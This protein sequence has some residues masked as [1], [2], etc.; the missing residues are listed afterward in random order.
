MAKE[1][2]TLYERLNDRLATISD[3][4]SANS[5]LFWDRQTHMPKGGI[6]SRAEQMAT[7]SRLAHEMLIDG[8]TGRLLDSLNEPNPASEEEA[9]VRRARREYER[10][11][12]LP[13]ELVAQITRA[14]AL[15]EPA[16]ARA[17]G[18]S[19]WS[20]F[21][22]H[23]EE[24]LPLKKRVAE[25]LGY[26]D[27]PY[28]ALLDGYEPGAKKAWLEAMFGELKAGILPL[29]REVT[30]K[31]NDENRTAPL[32]GAFDEA[33]Q[34]RFGVEVVTR[35]GYDWERGRQDRTMH[36]FCV[37]FGPGD[38]RITTRFDPGW[39]APALF[40]TFHEAGHALY[41]QG[42][43]PAYARTPLDG[44]ASMGVHESQSRLWENLVG[45]SRA[46]WSYFYPRLQDTF[47]EA[48][49]GVDL[50]TFYHAINVLAPSKIR[51]EADEATYN[52]HILLR[53]ELEVALFEDELSVADLPAAWNAKM[54]EYLGVTPE[55][56]AEGVL[57][58]I[59]CA[60]GLFGY[61]P[62]YAIGNVL[63]V[64]FFDEAV[65]AHPEI[66][67][68]IQEGK[69]STLHIWL[70]ENIYRYGSRYDPDELIERVSGRSLDTAPYLRYLKNKFGE[71][72]DLD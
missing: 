38:I 67:A 18:E 14:T 71:L 3:V 4:R 70:R 2:E 58:N 35:F 34:E 52:L 16:W 24:I 46:F 41:Q 21:A 36:P 23:L 64:Q 11:T 65:K 30:E 25:A 31:G 39:L 10:A 50:E 22:P 61:F 8:E 51:V 20:V 56:D 19:D 33:K 68:Q 53:F 13:V 12:K 57:Q 15:A 55:N 69:F 6:A 59:P 5:L 27:H 47:P 29:L 49:R 43:N 62:T 26:E 44:G 45:R 72:Y 42:I 63:S 54:E 40:G 1:H 48:L 9:L 17:R 66:P 28:D 60:D 32:Y 37:N 7:L